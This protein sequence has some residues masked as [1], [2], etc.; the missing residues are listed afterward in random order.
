MKKHK[1]EKEDK[2]LVGKMMKKEE[3]KLKKD[4]KPKKM[5]KKGKDCR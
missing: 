3:G 1:D 4:A 2:K 5:M